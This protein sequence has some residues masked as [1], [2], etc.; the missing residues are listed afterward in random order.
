MFCEWVPR[1]PILDF[2]EEA[3]VT[4]HPSR[5]GMGMTWPG[6]ELT[7]NKAGKGPRGNNADLVMT[8]ESD[9]PSSSLPR[10]SQPW[11][12]SFHVWARCS[13][14]PGSRVP[15]PRA[16]LHPEGGQVASSPLSLVS[17][18]RLCLREEGPAGE[19]LL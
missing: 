9:F 14:C 18:F 7:R 6:H 13:G 16:V 8:E 4:F 1:F 15:S 10:R 5:T 12:R 17:G 2:L 19:R 3:R 11:T